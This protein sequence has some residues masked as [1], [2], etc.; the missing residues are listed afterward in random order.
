MPSRSLLPSSPRMSPQDWSSPARS[1]PSS[2]NWTSPSDLSPQ[3]SRS[4][5]SPPQSWSTPSRSP[6]SR[7]HDWLSQSPPLSGLVTISILFTFNII[8][9]MIPYFTTHGGYQPDSTSDELSA[10]EDSPLTTE[11]VIAEFW[12]VNNLSYKAVKGLLDLL[13]LHCPSTNSFYK[14]RKYFHKK[15]QQVSRKQYCSK[16]DTEVPVQDSKCDKLAC[17][18]IE[19]SQLYILDFERS[20]IRICEGK[21][22]YWNNLVIWH[23]VLQFILYHLL[24]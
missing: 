16:R 1:P 21:A 14:L 17:S 24:G 7:R 3:P 8:A 9:V 13:Q 11:K 22:V 10:V 2:K 18:K 20:L 15:Q 5:P 12:I 6:P 23:V 4:P 19:L